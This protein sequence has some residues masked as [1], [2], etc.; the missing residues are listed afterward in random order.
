LGEEKGHE[1]WTNIDDRFDRT[2]CP[3]ASDYF[4]MTKVLDVSGIDG[5]FG[6]KTQDAVKSFQQGSNLTADRS[7]D[8]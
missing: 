1:Q 7:L 5:I 4:V 2:G 6:P 8:R 3:A